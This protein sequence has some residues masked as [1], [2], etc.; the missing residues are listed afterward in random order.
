M[1]ISLSQEKYCHVGNTINVT[2]YS[3][4]PYDGAFRLHDTMEEI[5]HEYILPIILFLGV[6]MNGCFLFVT[7]RVRFI[8]TKTNIYLTSMAISDTIF[9]MTAVGGRLQQYYS[10]PMPSNSAARGEHG[11]GMYVFMVN[12]SSAA[13]L[14]TLT[15]VSLEKYYSICQPLKARIGKGKRQTRV[16]LIAVW[17]ISAIFAGICTPSSSVFKVYCLIWPNQLPYANLSPFFAQCV[18]PTKWYVHFTH[19][20][21]AAPFFISLFVNAVLFAKIIRSLNSRVAASE[22]KNQTVSSR[23]NARIR[24]QIARMLIINGVIFFILMAPFECLSVSLMVS[25]ARGHY[26]LSRYQRS[27]V[28]WVGRVLA[29]VNA[30]INPVVYGVTNKRYRSAFLLAFRCNDESR[31]RRVTASMNTVTSNVND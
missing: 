24:T 17:I 22:S 6:T 20:T 12:I 10:T 31:R 15:L 28:A 29:Y 1:G 2:T 7:A 3:I 21:Q 25:G 18:S 19:I 8:R 11:C 9:L 16:E 5:I 13:S 14:F 26:L 4:N 30:V 27:Q 23:V